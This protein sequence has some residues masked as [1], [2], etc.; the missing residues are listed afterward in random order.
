[1]NENLFKPM[2]RF[3]TPFLFILSA[4]LNAQDLNYVKIV[5]DT[6]TSPGM[7]GRGYV[8]DGDKIA[9]EFIAAEFQKAG[10]ESFN[11]N[12][13]QSFGMPINTFPDSIHVFYAGRELAPGKEFVVASNSPA[14]QGKFTL[15]KLMQDSTRNVL[16]DLKKSGANLSDK[17]VITDFGSKDMK[18]ISELNAAGYIFLTDKISWHVSNGFEVQNYFT[19]DLLRE[20]YVDTVTQMILD[21]Q[22]KFIKNYRTRNVIGYIKGRKHPEKYFIFSAHYDHLGQMGQRAYFPG[23]ND[24]ASGTAM[25]LDLVKFYS[26]PENQPEMSMVFMAFS[27]EEA[28]LLGSSY[29]VMHPLFPLDKIEFLV[30]LDMVGSGSEGIKVVNGTVFEKDFKKLQKINDKNNYLS[31]VSKRGEAANS[32]HYPFYYKGVPSFFIYTLGPECKEYHNVYDTPA[33]V[34]FTK[35]ND[36]F[37]LITNFANDF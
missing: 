19:I 11:I 32:D 13:F 2:K 29:Y 9:S 12:Y 27:A 36:L 3:L 21:F 16:D 28:G 1:M 35:Y 25:L 34:P 23:A 22:N 20:L 31:K 10:L 30:N 8:N 37:K 5:I 18:Q 17:V 26:K 4:I 6:L 24:N 15:V 33:N 14:V 7:H